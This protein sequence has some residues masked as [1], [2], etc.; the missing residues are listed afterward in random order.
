MLKL[1]KTSFKLSNSLSYKD[2]FLSFKIGFKIF[3]DS[4]SISSGILVK[5]LIQFKIRLLAGVNSFVCFPV[6]ILPFGNSRAI[7]FLL[8]LSFLLVSDYMHQLHQV[9]KSYY[10]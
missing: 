8:H 5:S 10:T 7:T 3:G 4:K 6:I 1:I 9:Y 2:C